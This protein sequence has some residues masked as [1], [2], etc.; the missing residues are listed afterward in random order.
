MLIN[1]VSNQG[2]L[3]ILNLKAV[4]LSTN[5]VEY[6]AEGLRANRNIC[7]LGLAG[8]EIDRRGLEVLIQVGMLSKQND[9]DYEAFPLTDAKQPWLLDKP[10]SI[11]HLDLSQN[12]FGDS[13]IDELTVF[14]SDPQC[15]LLNLNISECGFRHKG[16]VTLFKS[17]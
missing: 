6:L 16:V 17:I 12:M 2:V 5:G 11:T 10:N 8:N 4:G 7:Q 14:L 9:H 13:G 15:I 3:T 1:Q